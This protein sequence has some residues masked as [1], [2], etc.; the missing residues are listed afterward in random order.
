MINKIVKIK[1]KIEDYGSDMY[2]F[3]ELELTLDHKII[4]MIEKLSKIQTGIQK[5]ED[6]F[7]NFIRKT[8]DKQLKKKQVYSV[9]K[10][11]KNTVEGCY[12]ELAIHQE[13]LVIKLH[14]HFFNLGEKLLQ[15]EDLLEPESKE[16]F[17][18][19]VELE[20]ALLILIDVVRFDFMSISYEIKFHKDIKNVQFDVYDINN[21]IDML[22]DVDE[23]DFSDFQ[24]S[25]F[26][27]LFS[28]KVNIDYLTNYPA[29]D[30]DKAIDLFKG[31]LEKKIYV[32]KD[33]E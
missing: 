17:Q 9:Y 3:E 25:K 16:E 26:N 1:S 24:I 28:L 15:N 27:G 31:L 32:E 20:K 33:S 13:E 21:F 8:I 5:N 11:A 29:K 22:D 30:I 14:N 7:K 6:E 4:A 2:P 10:E 23:D 18:S 12:D 19:I